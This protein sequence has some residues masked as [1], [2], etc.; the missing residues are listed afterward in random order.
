MARLESWEVRDGGLGQQVT[1]LRGLAGGENGG[2]S[3]WLTACPCYRLMVRAA[4]GTLVPSCSPPWSEAT[5][6]LQRTAKH[7]WAPSVSW[8]SR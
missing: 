6:W 7:G 1:G 3:A 8:P 5:C 2:S 4:P